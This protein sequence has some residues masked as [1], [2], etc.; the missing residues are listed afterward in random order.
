MFRPCLLREFRNVLSRRDEV[1]TSLDNRVHCAHD[2]C[3]CSLELMLAITRGSEVSS[4][5]MA[6][7]IK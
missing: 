3:H 2:N 5:T 4:N 1:T 7:T 6:T